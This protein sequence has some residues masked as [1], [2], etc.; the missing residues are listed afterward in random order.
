MEIFFRAHR[1]HQLTDHESAMFVA[2]TAF[3]EPGCASRESLSA[4]AERVALCPFEVA[5]QEVAALPAAAAARQRHL[6]S[7]RETVQETI[8]ATCLEPCSS[9]A[10]EQRLLSDMPLRP[11]NAV[12]VRIRHVDTFDSSDHVETY[13]CSEKSLLLTRH[14]SHFLKVLGHHVALLVIQ[15]RKSAL[16]EEVEGQMALLLVVSSSRLL[17]VAD[18]RQH[19]ARHC[20]CSCLTSHYRQLNS[21]ASKCSRAEVV[22]GETADWPASLQ[23][24]CS[25]TDMSAEE[26]M[27]D[28]RCW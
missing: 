19:A 4:V 21:R 2:R 17:Q 3:D 15:M 12:A 7:V 18:S 23:G 26:H 25:S 20:S 28:E 24:S 16:D 27:L 13:H 9:A 6:C 22:K 10:V 1:K 14:A 8:G 5:F 11:H